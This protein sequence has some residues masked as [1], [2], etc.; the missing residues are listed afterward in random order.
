MDIWFMDLNDEKQG[1][2][3]VVAKDKDNYFIYHPHVKNCLQAIPQLFIVAIIE[4][5]GETIISVEE[6]VTLDQSI[7]SVDFKYD[8]FVK[9]VH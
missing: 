1:P 9:V 8:N 3:I 2:H 5:E 6:Y 7:K 4:M